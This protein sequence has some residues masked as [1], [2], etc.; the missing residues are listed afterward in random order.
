MPQ[1]LATQAMVSPLAFA[2][3]EHENEVFSRIGISHPEKNLQGKE[4]VT[5]LGKGKTRAPPR[6]S[7]LLRHTYLPPGVERGSQIFSGADN[8]QTSK[9]TKIRVPGS[10]ALPGGGASGA[11][12]PALPTSSWPPQ[13]G[14]QQSL[15]SLCSPSSAPPAL[16]LFP[17]LLFLG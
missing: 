10:R 15:Q 3:P 9:T 11:D 4:G 2:Y 8:A 17:T 14:R 7:S 12:I 1:P 13:Q 6:I 16:T 5:Q